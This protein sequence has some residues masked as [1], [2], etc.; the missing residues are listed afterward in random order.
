MCLNHPELVH[1]HPA[2]LVSPV[3]LLL[4][5]VRYS[6]TTLNSCD[7]PLHTLLALCCCGSSRFEEGLVQSNHPELL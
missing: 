3:T 7:K 6:R 5:K 2:H 1:K 4:A